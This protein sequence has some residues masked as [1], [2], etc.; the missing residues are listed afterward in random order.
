MLITLMLAIVGICKQLYVEEGRQ[1]FVPNVL[2]CSLTH[3]EQEVVRC[4]C[5]HFLQDEGVSG[6]TPWF[7]VVVLMGESW[8]LGW[9]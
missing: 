5:F 6:H 3:H 9:N 7:V 4:W 8:L 2:C 1:R